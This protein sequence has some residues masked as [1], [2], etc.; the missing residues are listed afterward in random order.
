MTYKL[1]LISGLFAFFILL[2]PNVALADVCADVP[3]GGAVNYVID[4]TTAPTNNSCTFDGTVNGV[5]GVGITIDEGY[6]LTINSGQTIAWSPNK[7]V[8]VNGSIAITTGGQL[9]QTYLWMKDA[10]D[11][12]YPPDA[13]QYYDEPAGG[14]RRKDFTDFTYVSN[15]TYDYDDSLNSIYPGTGCGGICYENKNDG[16][17]DYADNGTDP[18]G[19]CGALDCDGGGTKYYN[20]WTSEICYYKDDVAA[21]DADCNSS[22]SCKS[23]A[24]ECGEE[25]KGDSTGVNCGQ[26]CESEVNCSGTSAGSCGNPGDDGACGTISCDDWHHQVGSDSA[27][28]TNYCYDSPNI[29][30]ARCEGVNNCKDANTADCGSSNDTNELSCGPCKYVNGCSGTTDGYCSTY[31][32]TSWV[33]PTGYSDPNSVWSSETQIY[34]GNLTNDGEC[35]KTAIP[36]GGYGPFVYLTKSTVP[37]HSIRI[38]TF[39]G[40]GTYI[41]DIDVHRGGSWVNVF[42][43]YL[44]DEAY[45][46]KTFTAGSVDQARIRPKNPPGENRGYG[47]GIA[48]FDFGQCY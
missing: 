24:T 36:I 9:K 23:V 38:Y 37:A 20:G 48:D 26:V 5:D 6:S 42:E 10:D 16:T 22:G 40:P 28:G 13:T 31:S 44:P 46:T 43:D 29:T 11:D 33:P 1:L 41:W 21:G 39:Y 25:P 17:C 4:E 32:S 12:G 7:S 8:I 15:I 3:K 27:S 47:A 45:S 18:G 19:D 34:N 30:S 2:I 35:S 14:K